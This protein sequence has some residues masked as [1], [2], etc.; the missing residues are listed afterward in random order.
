MSFWSGVAKG[1]KDAKEAKAEQE[2]LDARR[3]ERKETF[4]YNV[5]RDDITDKR[6]E[7]K[8]IED[9]RQWNITN[10]RAALI[11]EEG[12]TD[13]LAREKLAQENLEY[14][15]KR[16]DKYKN[17]EWA[18][19]LD[20]YDF[21]KNSYEDGKK[22][23]DKV[24]Q[25][26]IDKY[27]YAK[28]QDVIANLRKD[29]AE[30]R[31]IAMDIYQKER[32][33]VGDGIALENRQFRLKQFEEQVKQQG[34]TNDQWNQTFE[35]KKR[36]ADLD[37][38]KAV[39]DMIPASLLGA[40]SGDSGKAVPIGTNATVA[41]SKKFTANYNTQL[42]KQ[43]QES[44]FFKAAIASPS[45][46]AS[47]QAFVDAQAKKGN[48]VQLNE[49][50]QY[51]SY[52]GQVE[53]K[54]EEEALEIVQ[55]MMKGDG[56]ENPEAMA[57][58]LMVLK[59]YRPTEELFQQTGTPPDANEVTKGE[60]IWKTAIANEARI[61]VGKIADEDKKDK[62]ERALAFIKKDK[63]DARGYQILAELNYGKSIMSE[64]NLDKN[65]L[66]QSFYPE[67]VEKVMVDTPVEA[68]ADPNL[69]MSSNAT[70]DAVFEVDSVA[71]FREAKDSGYTGPIKY[72]G[73]T[74][75]PKAAE[76]STVVLTNDA[77][78]ELDIEDALAAEFNEEA[79]LK[80]L[81]GIEEVF[82]K[83]AEALSTMGKSVSDEQAE[84]NRPGE[85]EIDTDT[86]V[87]RSFKGEGDG[88]MDLSKASTEVVTDKIMDV[89]DAMPPRTPKSKRKE[90]AMK[91]FRKR[92]SNADISEE[93][94]EVKVDTFLEFANQ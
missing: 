50:P 16:E 31:Q 93:E 69:P 17:R 65:P 89:V 32:D 8:R 61:D 54:N 57:K 78:E 14:T 58:G 94:L 34:I 88:A 37:Y 33:K 25:L 47:L 82:D 55:S 7:A 15:W 3:A 13:R 51:F 21:Q 38:T 68:S 36:A 9:L 42:T 12:R 72:K 77:G 80:E 70:D 44:P 64:F 20:K 2:E 76:K 24:F 5:R 73:V 81:N 86:F 85:K 67:P 30:V 63:D 18:L 1:F 56:L 11:Y 4:E 19:T 39:V 22:H 35:L 84:G 71:A 46:Q 83:Q 79:K 75:A 43:E 87:D 49:L 74:Y 41:V 29:A 59:G 62:V 52:L 66:V 27:N 26:T 23:A 6:A 40:L 10:D 90:W 53:G 92:Y 91:E 28:D 60:G 48:E 45:A